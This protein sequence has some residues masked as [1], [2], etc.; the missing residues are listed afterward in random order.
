M[1]IRSFKLEMSLALH[2]SLSLH[3]LHCHLLPILNSEPFLQLS[4][5]RSHG[6]SPS[7]LHLVS[8]GDFQQP[9][10]L[11]SLQVI[12]H[13]ATCEVGPAQQEQK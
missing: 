4:S 5:L 10:G 9:L 1:A 3:V 6:W 7:S 2:F 8:P 12:L 13:S 11:W